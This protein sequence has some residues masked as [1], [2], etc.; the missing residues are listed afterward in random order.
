[1]SEDNFWRRLEIR[2]RR[3]LAG[4]PEPAL[5]WLGCDGFDPWRWYLDD[6]TPRIE[7]RVWF[8]EGPRQTEWWFTLYLP[9][10]FDS[11]EDIPWPSLLPTEGVT[12]WLALDLVG[13][14]IQIEPAAAVP[15]S[16]LHEATEVKP[17]PTENPPA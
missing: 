11:R 8:L 10:P 3:E 4:M 1:L 9:R 15:D 17:P 5:Q 13:K 14:R 2:V 16:A 7:G 6:E 12:R